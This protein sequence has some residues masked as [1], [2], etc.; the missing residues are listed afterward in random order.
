MTQKKKIMQRLVDGYVK[1]EAG[2]TAIEYALIASSVGLTL[3]VFL[4][5]F[6]PNLKALFT[7]IG[8]T[9]GGS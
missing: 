9:M 5:S 8:G 1:N 6:G 2:A 4:T 7:S 3:V